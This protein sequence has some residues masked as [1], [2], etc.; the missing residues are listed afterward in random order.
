MVSPAPSIRLARKR[1]LLERHFPWLFLAFSSAVGLAGF[2]LLLDGGRLATLE[3][4]E[5]IVRGYTPAGVLLGLGSVLLS[6]LTF[7]YAFRKR[8]LQEH[9]PFGRSTLATWLW[10]H[11]YLGLLALVLALAHAG[12]GALTSQFSTGKALLLLLALLVGSGVL[13]RLI[14]AVV[15]AAAAKSVG[16]YSAA[17]SRARA[18]A[19]AVEIEKIAAGSSARFRELKAWVMPRTPSPAELAQ[20][21]ASLPPEE[22]AAF[23]ELATLAATR[24]EAVSRERR[25]ESYVRWL[26]GLRV[27]HVPLGLLFV[28]LIPLHV[29]VAYDL[30]A[31]FL[32]PRMVGGSALGGFEPSTSCAG[33]HQDIYDAWKHSMHAHAMTS[34]LMIAQTNQVAQRVLHALPGPD[35]KEACVACHGPIGTMLTEGN[36]LPLPAGKLSDRALLDDGVGC[37][38]CHQWQGTSHTGGAAL[39]RFQA[40]LEPGRTFYGPYGDAVGNAFHRSEKGALFSHPEEL[41]RNCHSVELDMNDDGRFDRGTDLVLQTLYEEWEVYAKA[42]GASCV[43]CHMPRVRGG[44]RAASGAAIPFEQDQDAPPRILRDHSFVAVDYPLDDPSARQALDRH[45]VPLLRSAATLSVPNESVKKTA[46]DVSFAVTVANTGTG[47]YLPGGFA[48]VRQMWLEVTVADAAG[49]L[50]ASSG[51]L[52][53]LED[54]LCDST[55]VDDPENP[56]RPLLVGCTSAD[57]ALVNFQQ[58]LVDKIEV[59]RDASGAVLTGLRGERLLARSAGSREAVLQELKGGP[60][61]RARKATGK[62]VP[63]LP[64][65][66]AA[67]FP[68]RLAVPDGSAP[69]RLEVRLLFRVASPY[70]LRALGREQP[71]G[72]K[73]RLEA[74]IPELVVTEMGKVELDL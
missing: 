47:H 43:D 51:K 38:V 42:G 34:P 23:S 59:A 52:Q 40:G 4:L 15:P 27:L 74:L 10:S 25:Q 46:N 54:D 30:P 28:L 69:A 57:A 48:F 11:V 45:R 36:T 9:L 67:T 37:A 66:E 50:L 19:C 35:P 53:K 33:C 60:V 58:M 22:Q 63:P 56:M 6:F 64:P 73:P 14:Y 3:G 20:A 18:E 1:R 26:Q 8:G 41:C 70:F 65:G 61:P 49:K 31:R 17:A 24:L 29:I 2:V 55:I 62:P 13:W 68:Y 12:Y 7:V 21:L 71:P 39:T 5:P 72:E 44:K 16:N 32:D